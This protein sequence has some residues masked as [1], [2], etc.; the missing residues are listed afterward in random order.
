MLWL[1]L[2]KGEIYYEKIK[3][4][5]NHKN[6]NYYATV[7]YYENGKRKT[8]WIALN[9]KVNAR[10]KDVQAR[11]KEIKGFYETRYES[12]EEILFTKYHEGWVERKKGLVQN[13]TWEGYKI[14]AHMH[15][16]LYFEPMR[17]KL[18]ELSPSHIQDY[19][20]YKYTS[21]RL[22]GK[23]G[24]LSIESIIKHKSVFM[25]A[26]DE[27]V[28]EGLISKNPA[29]YVKLPAKRSSKRKENF[30]SLKQA[31]EMLKLFEETPFYSLVYTTLFYGLRKSEML[32]LK[33]SSVDFV[34]DTITLE[35]VVV[36]NMTIEEKQ[37]MKTSASYH[38]YPLIPD[39][40]I[41]LM[42]QKLWQNQNRM[43]Y[44]NEYHESDFVFTWE[45]GRTFRP[46]CLLRSFQR[47]LKRNKFT[48]IIT[49]HDLRHSTAS[50]FYDRGWDLKETQ[51]WLRHA[52]IKT[53]ADIYTHIEQNFNKSIPD[54]LQNVFAPT[55]KPKGKVL[56][57][58]I[59]KK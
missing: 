59:E 13:S 48:P 17:L 30:L 29:K 46:D 31:T 54:C 32:G 58:S 16:I 18:R 52:D 22:D 50:I 40:K 3:S 33:W 8:K 5:I 53:T 38:K 49:F 10:K 35:N 45:D 42:K 20:N 21:G 11:L 12:S 24:G 19:Y 28:L 2:L 43:K 56:E 51:M 14:Y 44:G 47:V 27:A 57:F 7:T 4:I 41:I 36:K 37:Q 26:L 34:N 1:L 15:I 39:V 55:P 9:L 25:T 23:E 6:N